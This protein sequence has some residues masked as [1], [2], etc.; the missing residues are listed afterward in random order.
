MRALVRAA[1]VLVTTWHAGGQQDDYELVER[2]VGPNFFEKWAFFTGPDP[3]HGFVDFQSYDEAWAEGIVKF[4]DNGIYIGVDSTSKA[5]KDGRKSTKLLSSSVYNGGLFVLRAS[6]VPSACG[7]WPAWWMFGEDSQHSWPRWGEFDI[8]EAV[9]KQSQATSTLHTKEGCAQNDIQP[10]VDFSGSWG[11][12]PNNA[13]AE[14]C[15]VN[16]PGEYPNQGCGQKLPEGS[17]G[18]PINSKGSVTT[19]AAEWDPVYNRMRVWY[20]A[21]GHEPE[22]LHAGMPN[23][24]SW[25]MPAAYFSLNPEFC[26]DKHFKNMRMVFDT[27][28]CGDMAGN[29]FEANCPNTGMSCNDFVAQRPWEFEEAY[30]MVQG[31]DVYQRHGYPRFFVDPLPGVGQSKP[32]LG[33][34]LLLIGLAVVLCG[35]LIAWASRSMS[36]AEE[37]RRKP[38]QV[39]LTCTACGGAGETKRFMGLLTQPC[40]VCNGQGRVLDQGQEA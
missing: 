36:D 28:F 10:G 31:L 6:H 3:T 22:D 14:N 29:Q 1:C 5:G 24:D 37:A 26:S 30:W 32:G 15:Y 18:A 8:I 7:I 27:T 11:V 25:G 40:E 38:I 16:A 21:E 34:Y 13:P 2:Y 35:A 23:P 4:S 33:L 39:W 20:F 12:G 9:H 17:Y 19:Y